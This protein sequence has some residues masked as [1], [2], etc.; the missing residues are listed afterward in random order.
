MMYWSADRST[1]IVPCLYDVILNMADGLDALLV[2]QW[3][4]R[5][6]RQFVVVHREHVSG[7][8]HQYCQ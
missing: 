2:V 5:Y 3:T 1:G 4:Q 6:T 7:I 8:D